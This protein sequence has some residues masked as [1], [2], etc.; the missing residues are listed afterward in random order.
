M[1]DELAQGEAP[2][3]HRR[4]GR[5]DARGRGGGAAR[6]RRSLAAAAGAFKDGWNGFNVLHT[7]AAR[8]GGLD[9][10]SCRRKGGK[11]VA[12]QMAAA[13]A[14]E[15]KTC[16]CWAP[17][18]S[19]L[20]KLGKAN[21][22]YLG[23]HGDAGAH[24][25]DVILP[26]AAYTEKTGTYVNTEGRVQLAPARRLPE[27]RGARGLGDP[28]RAVRHVGK[29][30]PYDTLA[31]LRAQARRS[32]DLRP[33]STSRRAPPTATARRR[34]MALPASC[35]RRRSRRRSRRFYL[36]NPIARATATMAECAA[37]RCRRAAARWRRSRRATCEQL[38]EW[39]G[40]M[41]GGIGLAVRR[42][43]PSS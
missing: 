11:D 26:G 34:P 20:S 4:P 22:I 36:T 31:Q 16:C 2:A 7:A 19:T 6:G 40:G 1:F 13:Q 3:D 8:V 5:A 10:A 18:R 29:T 15:I 37:L 28:A 9:W 23:T 25:A 27:G 17:T 43:S 12:A 21:V 39:G 33:G 32:S 24:R 14:G 30:L 35:R 42:S 38:F 41:W